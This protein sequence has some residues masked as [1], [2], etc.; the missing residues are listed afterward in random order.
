M[1]K[2][3]FGAEFG[4]SVVPALI[5]IPGSAALGLTNALY[6]A[7]AGRGRP[8]FAFRAALI[9]TPIAI[10]IYFLLVPSL[11][12]EGAALG[13]TVAYLLSAGFAWTY[14]RRLGGPSV[15]RGRARPRRDRGLHRARRAGQ[16]PDAAGFAAMRFLT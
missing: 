2:P 6:A 10:A 11:E 5:L 14:L 16:D 12:T 4:P 1:I 15:A 8:E 13:S 7:L 9:T 3:V